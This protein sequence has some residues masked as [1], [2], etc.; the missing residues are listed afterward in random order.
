MRGRCILIVCFVTALSCVTCLWATPP[1]PGEFRKALA[2]GLQKVEEFAYARQVAED[3]GVRVY[4]FGGTAAGFGHY[5]RESMAPGSESRFDFDF[6]SIYRSSQDA[7]LVV[8]GNAE[9]VKEFQTRMGARY[10]HLQGKKST[11]EVRPLNTH[12]QDKE[13]LLGNPDFLK[14]H[15]DSNSLG[16]IEITSTEDSARSRDLSDW[17]NSNNH[18]FE[19]IR[20]GTLH[21]YFSDK[22]SSTSRFKQ[23]N[24]PPIFSAIRF[25]TKALQ[26]GLEVS[27]ND[28]A[29]IQKVIQEFRPERDLSNEYTRSWFE[30][31]ARKLV[32]NSRDVERGQTLLEEL[33]LRQKIISLGDPTEVGSTAWWMNKEALPSRTLGEGNGKTASE[34]GLDV[35]AH[36]TRSVSENSAEAA[37][38]AFES[39]TSSTEGQP[40]VFLS[41]DGMPGERAVHKDGFYVRLGREGAIGN[42]YTIRFRLHPQARE[43]TDFTI[44]GDYL[45]IRNRNALTLVDEKIKKTPLEYLKMVDELSGNSRDRALVHQFERRIVTKGKGMLREQAEGILAFLQESA[46]HSTL[47][48]DTLLSGLNFLIASEHKEIV[49]QATNLLLDSLESEDKGKALLFGNDLMKYLLRPLPKENQTLLFEFISRLDKVFLPGEVERA[50]VEEVLPYHLPFIEQLPP[51]AKQQL[52]AFA[53]KQLFDRSLPKGLSTS[54]NVLA[55]AN[56]SDA[57]KRLLTELMEARGVEG[58]GMWDRDRNRKEVLYDFFSQK[59]SVHYPELLREVVTRGLLDGHPDEREF[60]RTRILPLHLKA[61]PEL[62][63]WVVRFMMDGLYGPKHAQ[64]VW[65]VI[66]ENGIPLDRRRM[67]LLRWLK[68][69]PSPG[70]FG[71]ILAWYEPNGP[72][73]AEFQNGR[74]FRHVES[75]YAWNLD[76][77][78]DNEKWYRRQVAERLFSQLEKPVG[79]LARI[80]QQVE[81]RCRDYYER[82][83]DWKEGRKRAKDREKG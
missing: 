54:L 6:T 37:F 50:F 52:E 69:E 51:L 82:L 75:L 18:F 46:R 12:H 76:K 72:T 61:H 48:P 25:L 65:E 3:L 73:K 20:T 36:E 47:H 24:N 17:E 1:K 70:W 7:D 60:F 43:G 30:K 81:H 45:V 21:Y 15:T 32:L 78:I 68:K 49:R 83:G 22:H 71:R 62:F 42:G 77:Q 5:V 27:P 59:H 4:L 66:R 63:D 67:E 39:I 26:Y 29:L 14:Q 33:G 10:P 16:L 56:E 44:H 57:V 31:N 58:S 40:N 53:R 23:G 55:K 79:P 41:R 2:E 34:L 8:D 80:R 13:K 11:W 9:Q 74:A 19:A 35:V 38:R 64:W 28:Q